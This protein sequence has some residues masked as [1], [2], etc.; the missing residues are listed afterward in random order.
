MSF[1]FLPVLLLSVSIASACAQTQALPT[2]DGLPL[3]E[4]VQRITS[5]PSVVRA[6]WGVRVTKLDGT[7]V[8]TMNDVQ[9][10]QPAS[11]AKLFTT[12]TAMAL[13]GADTTF[14]TRVI[15]SPLY[16]IARRMR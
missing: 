14:E 16:V 10:F 13:L 9:L 3:A 2:Y 6:H 1:R 11:N 15:A 12:A 4:R 5:E 7:P 8:F